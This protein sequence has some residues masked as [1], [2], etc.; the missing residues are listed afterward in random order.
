MSKTYDIAENIK[1][2]AFLAT[3]LVTVDSLCVIAK[4]NEGI[5]SAV[6]IFNRALILVS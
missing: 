3:C 4:L 1:D 6:S 2:V 5:C